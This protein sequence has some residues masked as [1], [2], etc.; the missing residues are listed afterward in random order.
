M[1]SSGG[2]IFDL[3]GILAVFLLVAANGFFVAAE[4]SLVAVR[5]SRVKELAMAGWMN[6]AVLQRA[7]QNLDSHLAA[8]QLGITISSLALG[9]IG[10]PALA[11]LIEPYLGSLPITLAVAG[12]HALAVAIA[13]T[14]ITALHIVL[15]ELAPKSLALQRSETTALWVVRPLRVFL[16]LFRPA[17]WALNGLGNL[18]LRGAG[19]ARGAAA[20]SLHSPEEL[21]LLIQASQE[22]GI[23][24]QAQQE[25]VVRVLNI[26]KRPIGDIMTPRPDVEWVDAED[27]RDEILR[28]IRECRHEQ[29]L[30]GSGGIDEPIGMVLKKDLLGQVLEGKPLDP[31][32]V[33]REPL[34]VLESTPIFK[35]LERFKQAPVRLAIIVDEYGSLQ[36]I[37]TQTD[38]LEAFAGNLPDVEGEESAIVEREDGSL[39]IDGMMPAHDALDRLG[40]KA[41][42]EEG[43]FHTIAGFV[44]FHLGHLPVAGES[45]T[46]EGWRFEIVDMDGLRIDKLLAQREPASP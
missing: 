34:V 35:V 5:R 25:V 3:L 40:V 1:P 4:F 43:D 13:F 32:A 46:H 26:G 30:V 12:S 19:L 28:T 15:G 44:L 14:I 21:K 18:V 16:F 2:S 11:R 17:I 33:I 45:F 8:T 27:S 41:R 10:E 37:V 23:L 29:L 22:A 20:E 7:I 31:L 6:A 36:G 24:Q 38:L 9:W 39:L 42:P